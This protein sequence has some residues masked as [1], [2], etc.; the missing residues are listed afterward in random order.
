VI[1]KH[2]PAHRTRP[3]PFGTRY[4]TPSHRAELQK[5][6]TVISGR[7]GPDTGVPDYA[8]WPELAPWPYNAAERAKGAASRVWRR[9]TPHQEVCYVGTLHRSS[10]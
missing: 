5:A 8:F 7:R 4:H 6:N 10:P 9:A 2:P 3:A 1:L